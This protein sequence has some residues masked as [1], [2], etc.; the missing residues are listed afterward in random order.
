MVVALIFLGVLVVA[1]ISATV[2]VTVRDG[3]GWPQHPSTR[4]SSGR[5]SLDAAGDSAGAFAHFD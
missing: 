4:P 1:A 3:Y 2:V 5:A